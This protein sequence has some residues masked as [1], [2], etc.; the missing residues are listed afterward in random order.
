MKIPL[1]RPYSS[2][3]LKALL[4]RVIDGGEWTGGKEVEEVE[5]LLVSRFNF[6]NFTCTS[7]ATSAFEIIL[8]MYFSE[9]EATI[10]VPTNTFATTAEVPKRLGHNIIF[11]DVDSFTGMIDITS[12]E[13]ILKSQTVD[14]VVPVS[15]GGHLHNRDAIKKLKREYG[16][17]IVED[18]AQLI[19]PECY[20]LEIDAAFF[21]FYPNKILSSPDGGGLVV[22]EISLINQAKKRRLHGIDRKSRGEYDIEFLGRKA[23]M[24]NIDAIFIKDQISMLSDKIH[25]RLAIYHSYTQLLEEIAEVEVLALGNNIIPSLF[26]IHAKNRTELKSFLEEN[27][28]Q[29]SIHFKPL[30]LHSYWNQQELVFPGA[31][32]YYSTTLSL[33]FYENLSDDELNYI[34]SLIKKF[35]SI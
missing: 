11:C 25:K 26:I 27:G 21:S 6:P 3:D 15:I 4:K 12:L 17:R 16:F 14:C 10:V 32:G 30:H 1:F 13:Q 20:D 9:I 34:I 35:Y 19:Y 2:P 28:V 24:T 22:S 5:N 33:P 29:T 7:S 18:L 8:D 31:E 23:N